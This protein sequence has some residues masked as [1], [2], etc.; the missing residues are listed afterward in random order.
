MSKPH[1]HRSNRRLGDVNVL[2]EDDHLIIVNKPAGLL[3]VGTE[4]EK[5]H[6]LYALLTDY[7]RRGNSKSKNRVFIV[8]RL[9]RDASGIVIFAKTESVKHQLQDHWD[10]VKKKYFVVVHGKCTTHHAIIESYLT[11][12]KAH[13]VYSTDDYS[14]GKLSR[15]AY[16]VIKTSGGL[17]LLEI[18]L[19]TG[20]KHQ[21]RVHMADMGHP[22]VGDKYYGVKEHS[23]KHLV[24]HALSI[25]F[26]HPVSGVQCK[27]E[28]PVPVYF[29]QLIGKKKE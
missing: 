15:T 20:R 10:E 1:N 4:S 26:I 5:S 13:R 17:S 29:D 8:H 18:E 3:T 23:H 22:V 19:L 24:L 16:K 7:V 2:H 28:A 14:K 25:E 21:I 12:N 11:E 6:T 27:F 9:D